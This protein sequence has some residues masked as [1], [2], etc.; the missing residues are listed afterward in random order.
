MYAA[1]STGS[2]AVAEVQEVRASNMT[3]YRLSV[4]L[5]GTAG[6]L[7]SVRGIPGAPIVLPAAFQVPAPFGAHVGGAN[8]N[9]LSLNPTAEH[10]SWLTVGLTTG[11]VKSEISSAGVDFSSWDVTTPFTVDDGGVFWMDPDSGPD[12]NAGD[13]VVAQLTVDYVPGAIVEMVLQGRSLFKRTVDP[14]T[15]LAVGDW[16]ERVVFSL[17]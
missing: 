1:A 4:Q 12:R 13:I 3:T 10:D 16:Q 9:L 5:Q 7:Y 14:T 17:P 8:S 15:R 6:N 2:S 11:L